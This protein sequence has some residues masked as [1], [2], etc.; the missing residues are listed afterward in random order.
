MGLNLLACPAK[1]V[2]KEVKQ[3]QKKPEEYLQK[4]KEVVP[5][6]VLKHIKEAERM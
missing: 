4:E 5:Q 6:S 2:L 1:D 3:C